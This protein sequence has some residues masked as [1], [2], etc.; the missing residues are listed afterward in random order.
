MS[1]TK[2]LPGSSALMISSLYSSARAVVV[3]GGFKLGMMMALPKCLA[4]WGSTASRTP[5]SRRW[6]CQSS[7]RVMVSCC[8]EAAMAVAV[9]FGRGEEQKR[10]RQGGDGRRKESEENLGRGCG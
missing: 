9:R 6:R 1:G 7:G 10:T 5:P 8:G 4:L 2:L 3:I